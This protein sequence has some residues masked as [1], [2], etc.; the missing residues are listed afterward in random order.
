MGGVSLKRFEK[1]NLPLAIGAGVADALCSQRMVPTG[2]RDTVAG[3]LLLV[4][5]S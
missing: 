2:L 1:R 4:K 5:E 3:P